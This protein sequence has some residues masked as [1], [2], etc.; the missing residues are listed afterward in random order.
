MTVESCAE[1]MNKSTPKNVNYS[2]ARYPQRN[3]T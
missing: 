3:V 1:F 2:S